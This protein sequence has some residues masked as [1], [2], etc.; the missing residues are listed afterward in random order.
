MFTHRLDFGFG[1]PNSAGAFFAVLA[2]AVFLIPG[3]RAWMTGIRGLLSGIF[4]S[5]LLL[6]ASRGALIG[7][8]I[9]SLAVWGASGFPKPRA[10]W[11]IVASLSIVDVTRLI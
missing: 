2:L 6:T 7:L 9:G 4:F 3:R 11:V 5:C 1:N 10:Q 8:G